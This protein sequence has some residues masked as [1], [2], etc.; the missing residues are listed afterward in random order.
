MIPNY[1]LRNQVGTR[2]ARPASE[3]RRNALADDVPQVPA[4]PEGR[5]G[6]TGARVAGLP[7]VPESSSPAQRRVYLGQTPNPSRVEMNEDGD[8]T[9]PADEIEAE[10]VAEARPAPSS[11]FRMSDRDSAEDEPAQEEPAEV[12]VS[13]VPDVPYVP[14]KPLP[15]AQRPLRAAIL[16]TSFQLR[17]KPHSSSANRH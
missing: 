2:G 10:S 13:H 16:A 12:L 1:H 8:E 5:S 15:N 6:G 4:R 17:P 9:L 3:P 14:R 7:G 11:S